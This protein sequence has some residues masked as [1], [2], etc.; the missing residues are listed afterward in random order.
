M[1]LYA[2]VLLAAVGLTGCKSEKHGAAS[3]QPEV[4]ISAPVAQVRPV[5][6]NE[7]VQRGYKIKQDAPYLLVMEKQSDSVAGSVLLGSSWNPTVNERV[8]ITMTETEGRTLLVA[9]LGIVTN[10]GTGMERILRM[11]NSQASVQFQTWLNTMPSRLSAPVK[12]R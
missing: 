5:V 2:L 12:A 4:T 8:S 3:G 1:K 10:A 11:Q 7:M 6:V 9:D